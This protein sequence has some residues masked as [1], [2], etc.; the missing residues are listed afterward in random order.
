MNAPSPRPYEPRT[1]FEFQLADSAVR[2]HGVRFSHD[3]ASGI[4]WLAHLSCDSCRVQIPLSRVSQIR[5]GHPGAGA[6]NILLPFTI[7]MGLLWAA[8]S[9]L[10]ET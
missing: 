10:P 8:F 1:I 3:S 4:P 5:R 6:W 2:L 7:G 9:S